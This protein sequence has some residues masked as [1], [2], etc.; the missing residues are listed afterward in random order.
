MRE[1]RVTQVLFW[2]IQGA[3]H[4]KMEARVILKPL[5]HLVRVEPSWQ[6]AMCNVQ[7]AQCVHK[8]N[9]KKEGGRGAPWS[10]IFRIYNRRSVRV[11]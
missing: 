4:T 9:K 6:R 5:K 2:K 8:E 3:L 7:C 10:F 11:H 1:P